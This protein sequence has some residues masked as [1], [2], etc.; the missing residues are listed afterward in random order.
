MP[1]ARDLFR[2][3]LRHMPRGRVTGNFRSRIEQPDPLVQT[4]QLDSM[5]Q[6][7]PC[8][9]ALGFI[10]AFTNQIDAAK[11]MAVRVDLEGTVVFH[12][13]PR[14]QCL[15]MLGVASHS[16]RLEVTS[17]CFA[18]RSNISRSLPGGM[19]RACS[20]ALSAHARNRC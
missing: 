8:G 7:E 12:D 13:P 16:V 11:N 2:D 9:L 4:P 10:I 6:H 1:M 18:R 20:R 17:P 14:S 5:E 3:R 19:W 15:W